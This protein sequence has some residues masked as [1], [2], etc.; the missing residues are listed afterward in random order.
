MKLYI[1]QTSPYV[2]KVRVVVREL[3]LG[4]SIEEVVF[5]PGQVPPEVAKDNPL[6]KVP[7][8]VLDDGRA[9]YDSP[10]IC[11]YLDA[12]FGSHRLLPAA[13]DARYQALVLEALADGIMDAVVITLLESRRPS[14]AQLADVSEKHTAKV[15]EAVAA[16]AGQAGAFAASPSLGELAVAVALGYIDFRLSAFA[17]REQYPALAAWHQKMTARPS[18]AATAPP[19]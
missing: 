3:G 4:D 1:T 9:I 10:V 12:T 14:H 18:M 7:T 13:G 16:I 17:W 5:P 2:R 15:H 6:G 8:L 11:E 19:T